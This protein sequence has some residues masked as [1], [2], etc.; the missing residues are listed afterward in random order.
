MFMLLTAILD[1]YNGIYYKELKQT[2]PC[3]CDIRQVWNSLSQGNIYLRSLGKDSETD[4]VFL[5]AFYQ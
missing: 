2:K 5:T 4:A 3:L 1:S